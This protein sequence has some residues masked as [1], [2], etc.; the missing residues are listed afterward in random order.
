[1]SKFWF[2]LTICF[3]GPGIFH[4]W[5]SGNHMSLSLSYMSFLC[6]VSPL[7]LSPLYML[8]LDYP[9]CFTSFDS[10]ESSGSWGIAMHWFLSSSDEEQGCRKIDKISSYW[11]FPSEFY[12][13]ENPAYQGIEVNFLLT[14][15]LCVT[16]S[17]ECLTPLFPFPQL[18]CIGQD[19]FRNLYMV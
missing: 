15:L 11:D 17:K 6:S 3:N 1:M 18:S 2:Y 14:C 12:I 10:F 13:K 8:L 19:P 7:P 9:L 5:Y 4:C 16:S